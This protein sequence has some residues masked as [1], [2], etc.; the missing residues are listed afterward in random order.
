MRKRHP[1]G[2]SKDFKNSPFGNLKGLPVSSPARPEK[3]PAAPAARP[4]PDRAPAP[5]PRSDGDLFAEEMNQLGVRRRGEPDPGEDLPP[6]VPRPSSPV[7]DPATDD[8]DA[9]FREALGR[10]DVT[11]TDRLPAD[12]PDPSDT[13]PHASPRRMRQ[14]RQGHLV[15]DGR[16]DLHGLHRDQALEKVRWYLQDAAWQG[17]RTILVITGRGKNSPEGPV[18][19]EAVARYLNAGGDGLVLEWGLAPQ[20]FGGEGALVVFLRSSPKT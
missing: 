15:P 3:P 16:L 11:F 14:L 6:L 1:D 18:L 13:A 4:A 5:A 10:M 9:W 2:K 19:R 20:R 12:D 17:L 8:P 7:P